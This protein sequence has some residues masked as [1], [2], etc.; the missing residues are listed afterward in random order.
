M[1]QKLTL[2]DA[3]ESLIAH[4]AA[5]GDEIRL[6][7]GP[8]IGWS[9]LLRILADTDCVRYPCELVFDAN[10][11]QSGECA[12]AMPNGDSPE[13]GYRLCVHPYFSVDPSRVPLLALYQLV[14]IN[15]G[16]FASPE[17][18]ET[19]GAAA[20]GISTDD[21]Y[22]ALCSMADEISADHLNGDDGGN[23]GCHCGGS[24]ESEPAGR[25]TGPFL[26]GR[27]VDNG[28]KLAFPSRGMRA[29]SKRPSASD[30]K[31][32]DQA[33]GRSQRCRRPSRGKA[34]NPVFSK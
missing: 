33:C 22:A 24:G 5:K 30:L 9:K 1:P 16:A 14:A 27:P 3:R 31:S 4:V 21:Y 20:L 26:G 2:E 13:D 8:V 15:Y 18:A 29:A 19:F 23:E 28:R 7:Y 11:L 10:P 25:R 34:D 6:K 17:D 12:Y 32:S